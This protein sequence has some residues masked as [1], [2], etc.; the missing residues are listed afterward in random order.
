MLN[1]KELKD[2][3]E[4]GEFAWLDERWDDLS[5]TGRQ[6]QE[7]VNVLLGEVKALREGSDSKG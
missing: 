5:D 7:D 3:E 6:L 1:E 4:R 2:I